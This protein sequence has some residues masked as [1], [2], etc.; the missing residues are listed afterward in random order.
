MEQYFKRSLSPLP[1]VNPVNYLQIC[2]LFFF[3]LYRKC[4]MALKIFSFLSIIT[5]IFIYTIIIIVPFLES[6]YVTFDL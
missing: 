4:I 1:S 2:E 3:F 5:V 6:F